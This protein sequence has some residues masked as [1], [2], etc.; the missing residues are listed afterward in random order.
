MGLKYFCDRCGCELDRDKYYE[1]RRLR[2][3]QIEHSH[4]SLDLCDECYKL[5]FDILA[6]HTNSKLRELVVKEDEENKGKKKKGW[7]K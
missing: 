3:L 4:M 1:D 5:V 6:D 7:L 2:H